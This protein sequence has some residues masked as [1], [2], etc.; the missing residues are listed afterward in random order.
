MLRGK[1]VVSLSLQGDRIG[2]PYGWVI[3]VNN[4]FP[5]NSPWS[6]FGGLLTGEAI[7]LLPSAKEI[8]G[9]LN[10]GKKV[11]LYRG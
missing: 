2:R 8:T 4:F 5:K 3:S 9:M 7:P 1:I 11:T 6:S 10:R